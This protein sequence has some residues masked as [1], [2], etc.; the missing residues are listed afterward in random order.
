MSFRLSTQFGLNLNSGLIYGKSMTHE[1]GNFIISKILGPSFLDGREG[2][3]GEV[4]PAR[5]ALDA[6]GDDREV[7]ERHRAILRVARA[8]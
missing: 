1:Y 6:D 2:L 8:E 5:H 3:R 4:P 7:G